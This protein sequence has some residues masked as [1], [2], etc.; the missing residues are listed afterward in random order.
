MNRNSLISFASIAALSSLAACSEIAYPLYLNFTADLP[1][2]N[3]ELL[4][5]LDVNEAGNFEVIQAT[6][7]I[8]T[9]ALMEQI[10]ES[11]RALADIELVDVTITSPKRGNLGEWLNNVQLYV[12]SDDVLSDDDILLQDLSNIDPNQREFVISPAQELWLSDLEDFDQMALIVR[13]EFHSVPDGKVS[14]PMEVYA[15][16]KVKVDLIAL[17]GML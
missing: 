16:A 8:D 10:P 9:S 11:A 3:E 7:A 14:I 2:V 13:A 12:S 4:E 6:E 1:E 5:Y 15:E 17:A